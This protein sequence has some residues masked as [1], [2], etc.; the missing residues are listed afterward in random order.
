MADKKVSQDYGI[1]HEFD[2]EA[3]HRKANPNLKIP[4]LVVM[5]QHDLEWR[6]KALEKAGAQVLAAN[7]ITK[8]GFVEYPARFMVSFRATD[9]EWETYKRSVRN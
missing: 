7:I 9:E 5:R 8:N 3:H 1:N 6:L 4:Y 2:G